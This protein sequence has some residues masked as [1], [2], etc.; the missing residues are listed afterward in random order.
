MGTVVPIFQKASPCL[1]GA[2]RNNGGC[3]KWQSRIEQRRDM[4]KFLQYSF[5]CVVCSESH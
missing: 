2:S 1:A 4:A 5:Q 3:W